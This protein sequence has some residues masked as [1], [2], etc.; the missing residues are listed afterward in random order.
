[1]LGLVARRGETIPGDG[2]GEAIPTLGPRGESHVRLARLASTRLV[3]I[4]AGKSRLIKAVQAW[5]QMT[6]C[7]D[8][9]IVT[10]LTGTAA[11]RLPDATT[12]HSA[13]GIPV[14]TGDHS[15]MVK[16]SQTKRAD[17][18]FKRYLIIDEVSMMDCKIMQRLNSQ[19]S[20]IKNRSEMSTS[21][22]LVT[23]YNYLLSPTLTCTSITTNL[24]L[25]TT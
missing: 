19:L 1:M 8:Q 17:W 12:L 13:V 7:E 15:T 24:N 25:D 16:V 18:R 3:L 9:S 21:F 22:S 14:E 23:S 20:K 6:K 10:A 5:F 4:S 2:L 11:Q